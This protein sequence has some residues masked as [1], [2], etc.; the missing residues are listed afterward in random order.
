L[1]R[2][3]HVLKVEARG[4]FRNLQRTWQEWGFQITQKHA[5]LEYG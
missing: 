3:I 2:L 5:R 1:V 4:T